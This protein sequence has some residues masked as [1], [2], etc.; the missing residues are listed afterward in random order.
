[1]S[2]QK[3]VPE[4]NVVHFVVFYNDTISTEES[5]KHNTS[6][7]GG[8]VVSIPKIAG[9]NPA[10]AVGFF[11]RKNPQHAFLRKGSKAVC[12]MLKNPITYRGSHK[13]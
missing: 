8:L 11:G 2:P 1:M 4:L 6:G 7:F 9:S 5:V 10:E 13:L 3:F 12:P